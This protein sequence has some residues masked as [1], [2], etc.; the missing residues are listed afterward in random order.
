[1]FRAACFDGEEIIVERGI[2]AVYNSDTRGS[3]GTVY[4]V[5]SID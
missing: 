5:I 3:G 2:M 4:L 1:M